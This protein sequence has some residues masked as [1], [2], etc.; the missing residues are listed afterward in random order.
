MNSCLIPYDFTALSN[1]EIYCE[2]VS[3]EWNLWLNIKIW[4]DSQIYNIGDSVKTFPYTPFSI[5]PN[6]D[7]IHR[8]GII[9]N[10]DVPGG[11]F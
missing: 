10:D 2:G 5:T 8:F 6:G 11:I 1:F 4:N 3:K 9:S 7:T